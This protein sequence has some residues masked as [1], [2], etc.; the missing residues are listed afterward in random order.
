MNISIPKT[1]CWA[2]VVGYPVPIHETLR[3]IGDK[4]AIRV[5]NVRLEGV[6]CVEGG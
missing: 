4:M 6:N 2:A 3:N 5:Y 1:F